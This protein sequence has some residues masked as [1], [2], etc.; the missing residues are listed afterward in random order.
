MDVASFAASVGCFLNLNELEFS[1]NNAAGLRERGFVLDGDD[2]NAVKGSRAVAED[3][4][5]VY[6]PCAGCMRSN[7]SS[8]MNFCTSRY[9]DVVQLRLRLLRIAEIAARPFDG[10][11]ED[12]TLR[13]GKIICGRE[14]AD[15][16]LALLSDELPA[17][18]YAVKDDGGDAVTVETAAEIAE[19]LAAMLRE[20]EGREGQAAD[21]FLSPQELENIRIMLIEKYPF[22][23]G[24]VAESFQLY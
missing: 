1:E 15:R 11:T 19:E 12:G 24:F 14:T 13:F 2:S 23:K 16:V 22:E 21:F 7:G 18:A 6:Q 3:A 10:I 8:G 20:T 4:F 9:K 17:E 5:F